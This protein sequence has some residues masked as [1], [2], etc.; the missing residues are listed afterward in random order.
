[1][2]I[3]GQVWTTTTPDIIVPGLKPSTLMHSARTL[4]L[5][6]LQHPCVLLSSEVLPD[7][8]KKR[9]DTFSSH[10]MAYKNG[11]IAKIY[12]NRLLLIDKTARL[13]DFFFFFTS[14][15]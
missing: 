13:L 14:C 3:R 9:Q 6:V 4:E 12:V 10:F 15:Y 5:S 8:G 1:M 2:C 11:F 7:N